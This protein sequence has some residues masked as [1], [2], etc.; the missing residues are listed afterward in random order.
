MYKD[1]RILG[2]IPA[3]GGSKRLPRKN[4][5]LLLGKPLVAWTIEQTLKSR[6]LDRVIVSTDDEEI[7]IV[8]KQLG[9]EVP[10]IRPKELATDTASSV[11]VA[12]HALEFLLRIGQSYDYLALFEPTSPLRKQNDI[13]NGIAKLIDHPEAKNLTSLGLIHMEHPLLVK[14]IEDG[15]VIPYTD[16]LEIHQT[17]QADCVYFPYGV[18]YISKVDSLYEDR[19]FFPKGS[20]PLFIERWQNY[21]IDDEIDLFIIGKIMERYPSEFMRR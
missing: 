15:F 2:L 6:F 12:I 5:K 16:L 14:K 21:E 19:T 11:D 18:I 3:R 10:F 9:A 8:S 7:A 4:I 13:D 20:I 17:Q 1:K